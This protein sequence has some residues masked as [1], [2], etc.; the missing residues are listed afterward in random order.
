V[1]EAGVVRNDLYHADE[2]FF[3][4]TAAGSRR[5]TR[6]TI[7]RSARGRSPAHPGEFFAIT[8]GRPRS[9]RILDYPAATPAKA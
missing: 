5:S 3:T 1:R 8:S 9:P 7:T 4:G 2:V 6:S